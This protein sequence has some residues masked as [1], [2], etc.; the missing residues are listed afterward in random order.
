MGQGEKTTPLHGE[1]ARGPA[2]AATGRGTAAAARR[3][4]GGE[5]LHPL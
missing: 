5:L 4:P 1:A 2:A 3:R